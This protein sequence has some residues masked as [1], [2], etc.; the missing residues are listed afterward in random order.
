MRFVIYELYSRK[1]K[2]YVELNL[3]RKGEIRLLLHT[4]KVTDKDFPQKTFAELAKTLRKLGYNL[5]SR[6][7]AL[8]FN[9]VISYYKE[10]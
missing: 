3:E 1:Q 6:K 10:K 5:K 2:G 9:K 7:N 8:K 4:F